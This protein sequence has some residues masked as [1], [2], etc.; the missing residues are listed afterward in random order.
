MAKRRGRGDG[1]VY[2]RTDGRWEGRVD[3][4][5]EDGRRRRK[6]VYGETQQEVQVKIRTLLADRDK[7]LPPADDRLTVGAFLDHWLEHTAKPKLRYSSHRGYEQIIRLHL[8]PKLGKKRLSRLTA[9]HV[10][11]FMNAKIEEGLSPRTVQYCHAVLRHALNTA[12]R[13]NLVHRNVAALVSAPTVRRE[14]ITPYSI[15]EAQAFLQGVKGHPLEA[16][17]TLTLALG[18]R[19][20]EVLGLKWDAV[21]LDDGRLYVRSALQRQKGKGTVEVEPKSRTSRR[22]LP[23]PSFVVAVLKD[24]RKRQT[25]AQ[26]KAGPA[27][28]QKR[29]ELG[30]KPGYGWHETGYVFTT[31]HGLPLSPEHI[32]KHH[33]A[34]VEAYNAKQKKAGLPELRR[35]RFHDLRH[36][37]ASLL[38]AKGCSLRLV[39]EILGHSQIAI[40]A[41][42]YTHLLPEADRE[43]ARAMDEVFGAQ[44]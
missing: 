14:P 28:Q 43:A 30:L 4:G 18:L 38:F 15:E 7:G 20:G 11:E 35:I 25:A 23:L 40:T 37:C 42:L 27:D 31:R 1:A 3:L 2:Q 6:S 16:L 29:E 12:V 9:D 33:T 41:N 13:R 32:Y 44:G 39:M 10:E 8:K 21:D 22:A 36:S 34:L 17:F 5:W 26:L 24:H 19:Q